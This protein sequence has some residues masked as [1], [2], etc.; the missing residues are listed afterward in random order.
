MHSV[1]RTRMVWFVDGLPV[2]LWAL[3]VMERPADDTI[4]T[5]LLGVI[6]VPSACS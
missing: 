4:A 6:D 3:G 1:D 2:L 5:A